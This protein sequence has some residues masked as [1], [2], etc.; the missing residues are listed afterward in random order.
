M[1]EEEKQQE[2]EKKRTGITPYLI[3]FSVLLVSLLFMVL[4]TEVIFRL[5]FPQPVVRSRE[6][7][8]VPCSILGHKHASDY[9]EELLSAEDGRP[10]IFK[11]DDRGDRINP[12]PAV[13]TPLDESKIQLL[14]IGDSFLE[15]VSC[16]D[17]FIVDACL[18]Q[19]LEEALPADEKVYT[20]NTGVAEYSP[21]HYYLVA[22]QRLS[23]Q[24]YSAAVVMFFIGNDFIGKFDKNKNESYVPEIKH[25]FK[26]P[27]TL[28]KDVWIK[29]V[30]YPMNDCL[31]QRSHLF[32]FF[33]N[34][35]QILFA[36]M[37]LTAYY[38]PEIFF[39][40]HDKDKLINSTA[41]AIIEI[42]DL[43]KQYDTPVIFVVIPKN[44]Q[45]YADDW[46]KYTQMFDIPDGATD[47]DLPNR[48][49]RDRLADQDIVWLDPMDLF[50]ELAET[51][52]ELLYGKVDSHLSPEGHRVLA[53]F[54]YP[55]MVKVLEL[56]PKQK[57]DAG[58]KRTN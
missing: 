38:I 48:L 31:E 45:I 7:M 36:R 44:F 39:V 54:L 1:T 30:L 14:F 34:R 16:E 20:E 24:K 55:E 21:K 22:K 58:D 13:E 8:Y 28:K 49:I 19:M 37:G 41:E 35:L 26:L 12:D 32:V 17:E 40:D 10:I 2:D 9:N 18:G 53:E 23:E 43:F 50:R 51:D 3:N 29:H 42:N 25:K 33:K 15:A 57:I 47:L 27:L 4:F 56:E 11:T 5:F 46:E 6:G 52:T